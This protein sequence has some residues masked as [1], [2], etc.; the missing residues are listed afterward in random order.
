MPGG[1]ATVDRLLE[2][3]KPRPVDRRFEGGPC[4][5]VSRQWPGPS[6]MDRATGEHVRFGVRASLGVPRGLQRRA[7]VDRLFLGRWCGARASVWD[8]AAGFSCDCTAP[9]PPHAAHQPNIAAIGAAMCGTIAS[10]AFGGAFQTFP[11]RLGIVEWLPRRCRK[12]HRGAPV[13]GLSSYLARLSMFCAHACSPTR[14][15]D[16]RG[17]VVRTCVGRGWHGW[18]G[19]A[20]RRSGHGGRRSKVRST[21]PGGWPGTGAR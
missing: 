13:A 2:H 3:R 21:R 8:G 15:A 10:T 20:S 7:G 17:V 19:A 14:R 11:K 6:G 4:T 5:A 1:S 9:E 18:F 16:Q 12:P